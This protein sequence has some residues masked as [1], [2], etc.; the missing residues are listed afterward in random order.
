MRYVDKDKRFLGYPKKWLEDAEQNNPKKEDNYNDDDRVRYYLRWAYSGCCAYCEC[1]PE[2]GSYFNIEHFYD[3]KVYGE[4]R[5]NILN[6]HYSCERCN[7]LKGTNSANDILSPNYYLE[8]PK[9]RRYKDNEWKLYKPSQIAC[10]LFYEGHLLF[11]SDK[12]GSELGAKAEN[13][14]KMFDLNAK[15]EHGRRAR[16]SLVWDR[17]LTLA[18]AA[19]YLK[20]IWQLL[21]D[22]N[23]ER[24]PNTPLSLAQRIAL[25]A[26]ITS[27]KQMMDE[28]S[29]YSTMIVDN[30]GET[31][32]KIIKLTVQRMRIKERAD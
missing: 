5:C 14:I 13:T 2:A 23:N 32:G 12:E 1:A 22:E 31:F 29:P 24:V 4:L 25:V 26:K 18:Q 16:Y 8:S 10:S 21:A 9:N 11:S 17:L 6:L 30:Y 15:I 20:E 27:L 28:G 7:K 19:T 3:K